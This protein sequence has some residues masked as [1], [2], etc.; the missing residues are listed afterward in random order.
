MR[1]YCN[2]FKAQVCFYLEDYVGALSDLK[3]A[4]E[5]IE[6]KCAVNII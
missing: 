5:K 3:K 2:K 4:F 1:I 6:G